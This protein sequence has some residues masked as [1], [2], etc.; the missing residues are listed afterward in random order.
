M[1]RKLD[2]EIFNKAYPIC[3]IEIFPG[4]WKIRRENN[5]QGKLA[6]GDRSKIT[7]LSAS[8]L[9][10][11]AWTVS[12]TEKKFTSML[13]LTYG[14]QFPVSGREVQRHRN[15]ILTNLRNWYKPLSY[16][17]VLEFQKRGAPHLHVILDK[18][19]RL[20]ENDRER[21]AERW[22][23]IISPIN[24]MYSRL[25][26]RKIFRTRSAIKSVH[27]D[28]RTWEKVRKKRGAER[29]MTKYALKAKQKNVPSEYGDVGRFWGTSRGLVKKVPNQ[30]IDVSS[31][32][33]A[34]RF[35]KTRGRP[36]LAEWDVLPHYCLR[37]KRNN[38]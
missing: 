25:R 15:S 38:E 20:T 8:S 33:E 14:M 26:D 19:D 29:Y 23:R 4:G 34:R 22:A 13:T 10:R 18:P 5:R 12:N 11:L 7:R 1:S 17:W 30:T 3:Q 24:A 2:P 36:D 28:K 32:E 6:R 35:L 31:D 27:M 37:K 9:S 21:L 16:L